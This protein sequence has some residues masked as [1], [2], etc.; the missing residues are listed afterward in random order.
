MSDAGLSLCPVNI[1]VPPAFV[2]VEPLPIEMYAAESI[3]KVP[4]FKLISPPEPLV[5]IACEFRPK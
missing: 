3:S 2:N 1:N 5:V 4:P